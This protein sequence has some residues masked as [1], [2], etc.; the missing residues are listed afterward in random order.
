MPEYSD[1]EESQHEYQEHSQHNHGSCNIVNSSAIAEYS[2][3][4][5]SGNDC[6]NFAAGNPIL[7]LFRKKTQQDNRDN[8]GCNRD[9][10]HQ[11]GQRVTIDLQSPAPYSPSSTQTRP[12]TVYRSEPGSGSGS[13]LS[14]SGSFTTASIK[15]LAHQYLVTRHGETGTDE[16]KSHLQSMV[17]T[18]LGSAGCFDIAA[19]AF[20]AT[21][22]RDVLTP[23]MREQ[24]SILI[25]ARA[26]SPNIYNDQ[27]E[28]YESLYA[29]F[30]EH[31]HKHHK[32]SEHK[33]TPQ[34]H[35]VSVLDTERFAY[36]WLFR[37]G[38]RQC[39]PANAHHWMINDIFCI[40][41]DSMSPAF[42][43][44]GIKCMLRF[45][46]AYVLS[47]G[48]TWSGVWLHNV[49]SG[50]KVLNSKF[51]LVVSNVAY[52]TTY[53]LDLIKPSAGIRPSQGIGV[54]LFARLDE[55]VN[56]QQY[57]NGTSHSIVEYNS[58]RVS[59]IHD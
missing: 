23:D 43:I 37:H 29:K 45:R 11:Y 12:E 40:D 20:L 19:M 9:V 27:A 46:R 36:K 34:G 13:S 22:D 53:R 44:H 10:S 18:L 38:H 8:N 4:T 28:H 7:K 41:N 57:D 59:V 52:P 1:Q 47:N 5:G 56:C 50:S 51:A 35:R 55:L 16:Q 30:L 3:W 26:Q 58:I 42:E 2:S 17:R 25:C 39:R 33:K 6:N 54:K 24:I 32:H 21:M 48:E 15:Y 14:Y 31:V 49:S